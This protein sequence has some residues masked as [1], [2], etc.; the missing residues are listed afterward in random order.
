VGH[1]FVR[2]DAVPARIADDNYVIPDRRVRNL[3]QI[4]PR[5]LERRLA[6]SLARRPRTRYTPATRGFTN[7]RR[8][9]LI[10]KSAYFIIVGKGMTTPLDDLVA[11]LRAREIAGAGLDVF[12]EEP[13]PED[14]PI[15]TLPGVLLTPAF[16]RE[17]RSGCEGMP[18]NWAQAAVAV[19]QASNAALLKIRSVFQDAR[20]RWVLNVL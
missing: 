2:G 13:L 20:R 19:L 18:E 15:R 4:D 7:R 5:M 10:K 3:G 16:S 14:H 11:A 12:A 17:H 6:S 1:D 8:F 9:G